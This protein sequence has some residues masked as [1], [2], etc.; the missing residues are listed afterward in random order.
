[1]PSS[2]TIQVKMLDDSINSYEV[3]PSSCGSVLLQAIMKDLDV[4][5]S[6]Y[7]GASYDNGDGLTFLDPLREI[8][9]Q[10]KKL[11]STVLSF[12]VKFFTPDPSQ[13]QDE[14]TR[15]LFALQIKRDVNN[16]TLQCAEN[17][18]L[19]I[20]SYI[21]QAEFGD[22]NAAECS[23]GSY[24]N[25]MKIFP[26]PS[27]QHLQKI[28]QLH[29]NL[30]GK[31]P[32][33]A[34][35]SLLDVA[36]RLEMYGVRL[37][38]ALDAQN[39][40]IKLG[41]SHAGVTVFQGIKR[42][43]NF[44]WSRMRKMSFKRKRFLLKLLNDPVQ[45]SG[46]KGYG[47]ILVFVM[48]SRDACKNFWKLCIEHHAFFRLE[49]R[50]KIKPKPVLLSRGSSFHYNGK[51][52][53]E[54]LELVRN[55]NFRRTNFVRT[56]SRRRTHHYAPTQ[57]SAVNEAKN[58]KPELNLQDMTITQNNTTNSNVTTPSSSTYTE[59]QGSYR[60]N[61]S[62]FRSPDT[63][64]SMTTADITPDS[65]Q[66]SVMPE[67]QMESKSLHSSATPIGEQENVQEVT[68]VKEKKEVEVT[69]Q[70]HNESVLPK[71]NLHSGGQHSSDDAS[72][73]PALPAKEQQ[74]TIKTTAEENVDTSTRELKMASVGDSQKHPTD[75]AYYIAKEFLVTERSYI[76]DLEVIDKGF[77]LALE[78]ASANTDGGHLL[79]ED[80]ANQIFNTTDS[81][82][83]VHQQ[84]KKDLETR[85]VSWEGPPT[86]NSTEN[87]EMK[88]E[89]IDDILI[90]QLQRIK[91]IF[92]LI[93]NGEDL[94]RTIESACNGDERID[95]VC[96]DFELQK[97]CY[98][99]ITRFLLQPMQRV[100]HYSVL[101]D[102]LLRHYTQ[103][104]KASEHNELRSAT[105]DLN[106]ISSSLKP[107]LQRAH[108]FQKLAQL[109]HDLIGVDNLV[110]NDRIFVREGSLYKLSR[111]G[112]QQRL[113]FLYSGCLLYTSKGV[114]STNQFK[115]HGEL[116]LHGMIIEINDSDRAVPNCFSILSGSKTVVVA[117][118]TQEEMFKWIE[119]LNHF[120]NISKDT[121]YQSPLTN[122]GSSRPV[123]DQS[124]D[125]SDDSSSSR[126][127]LD[128]SSNKSHNN[129]QRTNT[130]MHVCWHR[131]TSVS[132]DDYNI[133]LQ[134]QLC[135]YLLRKFKNSNGWQKLWVVFSNFCLFFYKSH[136]DEFPL[137][138]LPLLG[139]SATNPNPE[140]NIQKEYVFK[141]QFKTHVY[142][143]RAESQYTF[144][145]WM[146]VIRSAT[147]NTKRVRLFSRMESVKA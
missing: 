128:P 76:K 85:M 126:N 64:A 117:A 63:E 29:R 23:D 1:M 108:N 90:S 50:P 20:A 132:A 118:A 107:K 72:T 6:D 40:E 111:K 61:D 140:D 27:P 48:K 35:Y 70:Q 55:S 138:S 33:E 7:F 45:P 46:R 142:F 125:Q 143:F 67:W 86:I 62:S 56:T 136:Q 88:N 13:M 78:K 73:P 47:N 121:L 144:S 104:G 43:N 3:K 116:P 31:K 146:E 65:N 22:W 139:Y 39:A 123:S 54:L 66:K 113:F 32:D 57:A 60:V 52:Q 93:E 53:K 145:R 131:N 58:S 11:E 98:I 18:A 81:L 49:V 141:L 95:Q 87:D 36:R 37:Y 14:Y 137:A 8:G 97:I 122:G 9:R 94:V 5:E 100:I 28:S 71:V 38:P 24:L 124:M 101:F 42:I 68:E 30:I 103:E 41:V 105:N 12:G 15:Y 17:T 44:N 130:T 80:V 74:S 89:N 99:P 69:Q 129:Q 51:T 84:F 26:N 102:R 134:N 96:R 83:S 10:I 135:G 91:K 120:I 19:E 16:G 25:D 2:T 75:T 92:H 109:R 77:K 110:T 127:S 34:D 79:S 4:L 133:S 115:V 114:T 119:D 147:A 82:L 59:D 106:T 112:F 21:V